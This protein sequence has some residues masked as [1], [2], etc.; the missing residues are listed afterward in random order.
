MI[1]KYKLFNTMESPLRGYPSEKA[2]Y[3]VNL[4]MDV[5]ISTRDERPPSSKDHYSGAKGVTLHEEFYRMSNYCIK[6]GLISDIYTRGSSSERADGV[7]VLGSRPGW[8]G[9]FFRTSD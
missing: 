1:L 3:Y 8:Y 7:M 5:L 4:N 2:P 9:T 6:I